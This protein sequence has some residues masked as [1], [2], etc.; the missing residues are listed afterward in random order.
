MTAIKSEGK[1]VFCDKTFTKGG[2]NRHL[3]KHLEEKDTQNTTGRSFLLKVE[4]DPRWGAAPYF[5]SLWVDGETPME[6]LD[7]FLREI[8][9]ECCGH[10]SAFVNPARARRHGEMFGMMDA[11]ELLGQGRV[12]EYEK[13]MEEL[14]GEVPLSRKAKKVFHKDL[15]LQYQYDFG[16]TTELQITALHEYPIKAYDKIVL[17]SRNEPLALMCEKCGKHPGVVLCSV[18]F[19]YKDEGLFCSTCA[20][21]H[22]KKCED[23]EDYS[24]M[25]VVNSPRMGVCAYVG[26]TIGIDRDGVSPSIQ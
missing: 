26:G 7:N 6:K 14:K 1:C 13:A 15:K 12:K 16:S 10:M 18:C 5:L 21:K 2:I 20:K 23:F 22:A 3:H 25:P 9:L 4:A 24:A 8:W 19:S 11:Y 17:L